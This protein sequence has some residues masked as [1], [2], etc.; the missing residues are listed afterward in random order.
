MATR[1][2]DGRWQARWRPKGGEPMVWYG[3]TAEEAEGRKRRFLAST[4]ASSPATPSSSEGAPSGPA[5]EPGT[6]DHYALSVWWP[7]IE[8]TTS[9][10]TRRKY[11]ADYRTWIGPVLGS[12]RLRDIRRESVQELVVNRMVEL[13]RAPSTVKHV[14]AL[15]SQ[16]LNDAL[17]EGHVDRNPT[18]RVRTPRAKGRRK[19]S[20]SPADVRRVLD[21]TE[22]PLRCAA[23][24]AMLLGLRE[25]EVSALT[26]DRLDRRLKVL[27]VDRQH[28][29]DPE[30]TSPRGE[31]GR[32][33]RKGRGR[34]VVRS[35]KRLTL[36]PTKNRETRAIALPQAMVDAIDEL[37]DLDSPWVVSEDGEP[38]SPTAIR[39]RWERARKGLGLPSFTFH[40]LR[41][42]AAGLLHGHDADAFTIRDTLGHR[43]IDL[44]HVYT[45]VQQNTQRSAL[46]RVLSAVEKVDAPAPGE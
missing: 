27:T 31:R 41:H 16:I 38:L 28:T 17:D 6:L 22:G 13:G 3:E 10:N 44:T 12:T 26:W 18:L 30:D 35:K 25:G 24:L 36:G 20:L 9:A 4:R 34:G 40:D 37:G 42:V 29:E 45:E 1:L 46:E 33:D 21:G 19:R 5:I 8:A 11:A 2:G 7:G 15:L 43:S 23:Y 32:P 39:K 14:K